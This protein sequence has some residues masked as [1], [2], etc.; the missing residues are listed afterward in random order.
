MIRVK[1]T[2]RPSIKVLEDITSNLSKKYNTFCGISVNI[3]THTRGAK[4]STNYWCY[5]Q[6]IYGEH[7]YSW[8][9]V[10][11]WYKELIS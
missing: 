3:Q 10:L 6:D 11:D 9:D 8:E 7:K 2:K 5:I 4:S 1:R